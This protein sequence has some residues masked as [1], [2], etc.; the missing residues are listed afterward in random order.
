MYTNL[1]I[2][3]SM[4][5]N[6][7]CKYCD[8]N[9]GVYDL[10]SVNN[11]VR[12]SLE[13]DSFYNKIISTFPNKNNFTTIELWGLEPTFNLE[14]G[15][16]FLLKLLNY[17]TADSIEFST[18]TFIGSKPIIKFVHALEQCNRF[19]TFDLQISIDGPAWINDTSRR[20]GAT[21]NT[22][23]V[24]K[25]IILGCQDLKNVK[26]T[27]H[28]KPTLDCHYMEILNQDYNKLIEYFTFLKNVHNEWELLNH[29]KNIE[30]W[31]S[32]YPTMVIP[33]FHTTKD[34]FIFRDFI[35]GMRRLN[36][37]KIFTECLYPQGI[38]FVKNIFGSGYSGYCGGGY[39]T[40]GIDCF[41]N[42]YG[43]HGLFGFEYKDEQSIALI[44]GL[45]TRRSNTNQKLQENMS[46][47][48]QF[49]KAHITFFDSVFYMLLES[50]Q[51][52]PQYKN[53]E[54]KIAAYRYI[55]AMLCH[56]QHAVHT[57]SIWVPTSSYFKFICNGALE[58]L[59]K[60]YV[61]VGVLSC[62]L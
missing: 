57:K 61:E 4:N 31:E 47:M 12:K 11:K 22:I 18:N 8:I 19:I 24:I 58:E 53:P 21:D 40:I 5:C 38:L 49:Y 39:H 2:N 15:T 13:D 33:N 30:I 6:M 48:Y 7:R 32:Y 42:L 34:G 36:K 1:A 23:K 59:I 20:E 29:T 9:D 62:Q 50:G 54:L 28:M 17:Y 60:Y 41:G 26:I 14:I 44:D 43:C 10:I 35:R 25:E 55:D 51:I 45:T 56:M 46:K 52:Q 27:M 37:D 16:P 3:F